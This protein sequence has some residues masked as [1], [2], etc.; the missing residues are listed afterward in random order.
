MT[1]RPAIIMPAVPFASQADRERAVSVM[2][3]IMTE[4]VRMRQIALSS[5]VAEAG[6]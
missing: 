1:D 2:C 5:L 4:E 3:P 6:V